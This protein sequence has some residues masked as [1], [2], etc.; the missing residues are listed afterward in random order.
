MQPLWLDVETGH[1]QQV[2]AKRPS[3]TTQWWFDRTGEPR[4]ALAIRRGRASV[5]TREPGADDWNL[6]VEGERYA[7]PWYPV[8]MD[9]RGNLYGRRASADTY[10]ELVRWDN[11]TRAPE[12]LAFVSNPGFDFTGELI[13]DFDSGVLLGVRVDT[14]ARADDMARSRR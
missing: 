11:T 7:M 13:S 6:A 10:G 2:L 4:A 14:D 5:Y 1:T 9:G 12:R 3:D 8:M